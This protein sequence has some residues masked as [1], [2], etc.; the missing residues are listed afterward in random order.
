MAD[1]RLYNLMT[2]APTRRERIR[3]HVLEGIENVFPLVGSKYTLELESFDVKPVLFSPG[4]Q[5]RAILEKKTLVEPLRATVRL[6]DSQTGEVVDRGTRTLAHIP[7]F[8]ERHT[9][10][11]K[12]NDYS[13]SNQVR[14]KPGV[15]TRERNNG[16][17]EAAFNL[18]KGRNFRLEM[19]PERGIFYMQYGTTRIPLYPVLAAMK[20]TDQQISTAWGKELMIVNKTSSAGKEQSA[21]T[22]LYDKMVPVYSRVEN[23]TPQQITEAL[24]AA[25]E[26]TAM[27]PGV[28]QL[29][30]GQP[31]DKVNAPALLRASQKLV[32]VYNHKDTPDERDSLAFKSLHTAESF[33]K[34][35]VE[36]DAGR[37]FKGKVTRK[38]NQP[39]T[40]AKIKDFLP[41]APFSKSLHSFLTT[42]AL[43]QTPMQI[44]PI[45]I[46]DGSTRVTSLGEGGISSMLAV[47]DEARDVHGSHFGI[48]DPVRTPESGKAGIDIRGTIHMA[49]NSAG[50]MFTPLRNRKSG[51]TEFVSATDLQNRTIAFP[52]QSFKGNKA[53]DALRNGKVVSV[54][55]SEVDYVVPSAA[56]LYSP[57]TNL[58]P[59]LN[60]AM[61]N[62]NIMGAKFQTQAV[63]LKEREAPFV[64][65][66]SWRKGRSVEQEYVSMI[67][68]ISPISGT[69]EKIDGDFIYIRPDRAKTASLP[70]DLVFTSFMDTKEDEPMKRYDAHRQGKNVGYASVHPVSHK[71]ANYGTKYA[72]VRTKVNV[73]D[74]ELVRVPYSTNFPMMS[75]TYMHD[76]LS[77]KVGDKVTAGQL[78]G[79]SNFTKGDTLAL[80]KNMR[81]AYMPYLGFNSNDAIVIS[82]GAAKKFT[83]M[84]MYRE[85]LTLDDTTTA[86]KE[87][88]RVY[89]GANYDRAQYDKLSNNGAIKVGQTVHNGELLV[90]AMR[91]TQAS[92]NAQMLGRLHKSL[93]KP[94]RD[95]SITWQHQ[96]PGVVTDVAVTG[97]VI[98]VAVKTEEPAQLGDKLSNREGGKGVI[99]RIVPDNQ[100]IQDE[101]GNPL[102]VLL[103]SAGII[104][105][106][107]PSQVIEAA[108]GK[109]VAK[110][111][112][113]INI[114][115]FADRDNVQWAK[116][117][118]KEHGVKDKETV[119]DPIT[120]KSIP[121]VFVGNQ[122]TFKM[123][124]ST[125]TNYAARGI[126]PGY[127]SNLQ[128]S[129]GGEDGAKGIGKMEFNALIAHNARNILHETS[130][131]KSQRN[132]EY[133][134]R[135]QLGL[136]A[137]A[138]AENFAYDKFTAM[139]HGSG[140]KTNKSGTQLTLAP[141]TDRD[142]DAMSS[143][144]IKSP[145]LVKTQVGKGTGQIQPERGG[146]FDPAMTG[147]MSGTKYTKIEL[148]EPV[149]NPI[150]E[151]PVS[152]L[153]GV[154][155]KELN[156][157]LE[158]DGAGGIKDRLNNIDVA[159][160]DKEL[161][162]L[163]RK[164]RGARRDDAVK[165]IKYLQALKKE[166]LRPGDAYI[167]S[168]V[169]VTPPVMRPILPSPN[170]SAL[171]A[172]A[173]YLYR[174]VM[175]A[176]NSIHAMPEELRS[177]D[178]MKRMRRHL[179]DSVGALFGMNDPVSPQNQ[180]RGVKG[181]LTQITGVGS[182]KEG[183]FQSRLVKRKQDL[184]GRAT[185]APDH[186]L[187]LDDVGLPEDMAWTMY[188]PFLIKELVK[189]GYSAVDAKKMVTARTPTAKNMLDLEVQKRPVLINRAPSLHRWNIVA[190][191]P[192][193]IP[194]KTLKIN[195]F[196]EAG[197]N[198]DFDG[199]TMQIHTPVSDQA[200]VEA[201][202]LTISNLVFGDRSKDSLMVFPAHEAIIGTYLATKDRNNLAP[203]KFKNTAEAKAAYMRGDVTLD[204]PV[205]IGEK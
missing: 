128:P 29:T 197:M 37:E 177:P 96:H 68:P 30:L 28:N 154:S 1:E 91:S 10:L 51:A 135:I 157:I 88:H 21:L 144:T 12:G 19:D 62:R 185:I 64:Q 111:G 76:E 176:N 199:D 180:G 56:S 77:A 170:G 100:M 143:G 147:G 36:K 162:E 138:P 132:D 20:I 34:E 150:F 194:G 201:Q 148:Y 139:L 89:F 98:T 16:E 4:E 114:P 142:I 92:S 204:T 126:G 153:L 87:K 42:S 78:L 47:P 94:F 202:G 61:G 200:V 171:I 131:I 3:E 102:D 110:T 18:S 11:V 48:L 55:A 66:E 59:M 8:T 163:V 121:N 140:I 74:D 203:R 81:M 179:Q 189:R 13:V 188:E 63:P 58:V 137:P 7:Y 86:D 41:T 17:L 71:T 152:R 50:E 79:E 167:L 158:N 205:I 112:K 116:D 70:D 198:A 83:S 164:S 134:R 95:A 120:G 15:Y 67:S 65:V 155:K 69:V 75:K 190:A 101:D 173:N 22:K 196:V 82:E 53:I 93:V 151:D 136:P 191:Y 161:R 169:P 23:P 117:L 99:S 119:F 172:D 159:E 125:D 108:V 27:D 46:I 186:T 80:G 113:P 85:T 24:L 43:S 122:Y 174:D 141:L 175:L 160:K 49:R 129:K 178:E 5:K 25:Y 146:L 183:Y 104:T 165:Q 72:S 166:D 105:R 181:H 187:G 118:L 109:V 145:L 39:I 33:F 14:I 2:D 184:S 60:S 168:K 156:N 195:P 90:A 182:P 103:T 84:H 106:V 35:R 52:N 45:E 32:Q 54:R 124:K 97:N 133:W 73:E 40:D 107:N 123:F 115:Q 26:Q 38:L 6:V 149:L 44:N 9:F 127:D 31:Y 192:Q 57:A 193:I 130:S